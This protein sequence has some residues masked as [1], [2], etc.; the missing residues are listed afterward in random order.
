MLECNLKTR[1]GDFS[2]QLK[3]SLPSNG[4]TVIFGQSGSGKSSLLNMIA[5]FDQPAMPAKQS[6]RLELSRWSASPEHPLTARVIVNRLWRWHFGRGLVPTPDNFGV[7]GELPSHPELLD[8]L[9]LDD[10]DD[11]LD[12]LLDHLLLHH[13]DHLTQRERPSRARTG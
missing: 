4:I 5:G 7:L 9:A 13:L 3:F 8:H 2:L 1:L 12:D 10:L 11:L 6:G